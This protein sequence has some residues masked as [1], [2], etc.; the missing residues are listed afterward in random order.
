MTIFQALIL[1][2]IQ[3]ITEFLPVSSSAHLVLTPYLLGWRLPEEQV[4]PF[5]VLV[6]IGTLIAVIVYFRRDLWYIIDAVL[7][8]IKDRKPFADPLARLGWYILLATIPAGVIGLLIKDTVEAA[9]NS[10]RVTAYFLLG[11]ALLLVLAELI[12]KRSRDLADLTWKDALWI[13]FFQALSLFPGISRSGATISGGMLRHIDRKSAGRF[14]F[15]MMIPVMLAA[16]FLSLFDL[17]EVPNLSSFLAPMLTG[18]I[19]SALVG[20]LAI[21]WLLQF[22][23]RRP[24]YV[25][26]AYVVALAGLTLWISYA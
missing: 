26:A 23:A 13:G 1:G 17:F 18:F 7:A 25:F 19:A 24:L 10:P 3:G 22:I 14:S 5:D 2:I 20:Y 21:H 12:G 11:T 15:L 8:G 4:F 16:G 9:F 6:Q